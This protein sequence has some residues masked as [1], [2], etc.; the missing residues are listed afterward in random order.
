MDSPK[1]FSLFKA[2]FCHCVDLKSKKCCREEGIRTL[3]TLLAYTHFPGVRLRPLGHLSITELYN[4]G[5]QISQKKGVGQAWRLN[6]E[7]FSLLPVCEKSDTLKLQG[8]FASQRT[9]KL[10]TNVITSLIKAD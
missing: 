5:P 3:D 4:S 7:Q 1:Y 9:A 8:N 2:L 10:C 6:Y